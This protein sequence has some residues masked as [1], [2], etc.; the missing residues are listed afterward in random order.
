MLGVVAAVV[1]H[2]APATA[3]ATSLAHAIAEGAV[4]VELPDVWLASRPSRVGPGDRVDVFGAR[5]DGAGSGVVL[6]VS[7]ARVLDAAGDA[8]VLEVIADDAVALAL[9]RA[10]SYLLLVALRP[11]R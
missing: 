11:I 4:A 3:V 10:S 1:P 2:E 6:V 7:E 5:P 8:L 9:A